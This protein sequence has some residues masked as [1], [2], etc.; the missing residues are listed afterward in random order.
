[1]ARSPKPWF[2]KARKGWYVELKGKQVRLGADR[3]EADREFY[4]LMA[5]RGELGPKESARMTVA[6]ACEAMIAQSQDLKPGTLDR[7]TDMFGVLCDRFGAR[8]LDSLTP[9]EVIC[10]IGEYRGRLP[11]TQPIGDSTRALLYRYVRQLYR[12]A[13]DTGLIDINPFVRVVGPWRIQTRDRPMN[14]KEYEFLMALPRMTPEMKEVIEFV[15]RTGIR[16]G[17]LAMLSAKHLDANLMIARFQPTEHKTGRKTG[18]QREVYFPADLWAR[19]RAY[20]DA[21]PKGPIVLRSNGTPWTSK[22][23]SDRFGETKRRYKLDCVLYQARHRWATQMLENG[24]SENHVARMAGHASTKVLHS[25]YYHPEAREMVDEVER[26]M[27]IA[28][29]VESTRRI[30]EQETARREQSREKKRQRQNEWQRRKRGSGA[31][32][33]AQEPE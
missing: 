2:W 20:A 1:M 9:G 8:R 32:P 18:K 30:A 21:R 15:W 11:D 33:G 23:I 6:D 13:R 14:E 19:L 22:A 4:R 17:E 3:K 31:G 16:P 5:S 27:G 12:W 29:E 10:W 25:T 24:V 26:V 7:Y 28:A